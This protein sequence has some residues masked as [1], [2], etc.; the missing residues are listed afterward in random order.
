MS[1]GAEEDLLCLAVPAAAVPSS[2]VQDGCWGQECPCATD[3]V[4][5]DS[6]PQKAILNG[7]TLVKDI[8]ACVKLLNEVCS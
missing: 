2:S 1:A 5:H 3:S 4:L 6:E 7:A 8:K